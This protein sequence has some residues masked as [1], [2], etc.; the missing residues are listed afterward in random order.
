MDDLFYAIR[1][2]YCWQFNVKKRLVPESYKWDV[3]DVRMRLKSARHFSESDEPFHYND[4]EL[5]MLNGMLNPRLQPE[6]QHFEQFNKTFDL[7]IP[8][9]NHG[10]MIQKI[11]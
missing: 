2:H 3:D 5:N 9:Q 1:G 6:G 4:D 10:R 7:F 11:Q 8:D